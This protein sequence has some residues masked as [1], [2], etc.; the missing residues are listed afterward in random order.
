MELATLADYR[1]YSTSETLEEVTLFTTEQS[2]QNSISYSLVFDT[3]SSDDKSGDTSLKVTLER[4]FSTWKAVGNFLSEY[5]WEKGFS[6]RAT[7]CKWRV[8]GN[9]SKDISIITFT[10]V[11]NE[12]NHSMVPS[13]STNIAKYY[14]LGED[15]VEFIEF[16][17]HHGVTSAQS[18]G[19]LLKGKF[20][21]RK[22]YQKGLYNAIQA[23]KKKLR[24]F[25]EAKFDGIEHQL[26]ELVWLSPEQQFLWTCYHDVLFFDTTSRTN[27]YNMVACFFAMVDNCNRTRLVATVLLE[28]ETKNSFFTASANSTQRV[29]SLNRKIHD[30]VRSN[31]SLLFL[32]KEIQE[33]LDKESEY[34]RVEEYKKQIPTIGLLTVSKTYFGS[35][36]KVVSYYLLPVMVF[37]VCRQMQKC[38]YY[39]S[40]QIDDTIIDSMIQEQISIDYSEGARE[41]NYEVTKIHLTDIISAINRDQILEVWRVVISCGFNNNYVIL[42]ADGSHRCT[43]NTIITHGYPCRHFYKVLRCSTQARWHIGLIAARWYKD[44]FADG[45]NDICSTLQEV[46]NTRQ[47]YGRMQGLMRKALDLAIATNTYNELMGIC[48]KFILDKQEP[49]AEMNDIEYDIMNPII[50]I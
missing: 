13:P 8:N 25:I 49:D 18:I 16:C 45:N 34:V 39:D 33:L 17:I 2:K 12:H 27:K 36:E 40:F 41:D 21:G 48:Y 32:V 46:N 44:N 11:V 7:N 4:T 38:F 24:W 19:R 23:A 10:T 22:V 47:K 26:C 42:L 14:K 50:T 28:D 3:D 15:M 29:E 43:C 9:L 37:T 35:I 6:S 5:G 20:S 31:L 1:L 30:C